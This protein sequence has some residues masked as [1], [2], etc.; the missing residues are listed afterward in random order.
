MDGEAEAHSLGE[1]IPGIEVLRGRIVLH[2]TGLDGGAGGSTDLL[3]YS[4]RES[5]ALWAR[6]P[7]RPRDGGVVST[8]RSPEVRGQLQILGSSG[9]CRKA[10]ERSASRAATMAERH[11]GRWAG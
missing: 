8:W 9:I 4:G 10:R 11:L 2:G 3:V 7:S 6:L 1:A 5:Y